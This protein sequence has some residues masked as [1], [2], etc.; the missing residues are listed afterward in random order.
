MS[1]KENN[2]VNDNILSGQGLTPITGGSSNESGII[3]ENRGADISGMRVD[4]LNN[5][6]VNNNNSGTRMNVFNINGINKK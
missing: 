1:E 6:G 4:S 3:A 2:S 5:T